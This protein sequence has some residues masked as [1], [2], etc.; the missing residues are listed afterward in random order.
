MT[1]RQMTCCVVVA[2]FC[3][4]CASPRGVAPPEPGAPEPAA[5]PA[6]VAKAERLGGSLIGAGFEHVVQAGDTLT[7]VS[8]RY[9]VDPR[10]LARENGLERSAGLRAGQRLRVTNLHI[11]PA[12][13]PAEGILINV[14]QRMLFLFRA[15][16]LAGA[17][18]VGLGRPDWQTPI[19]SYRIASRERDKA[20]IV[21]R[22]IQEEMRQRGRP[23][24]TRVEPGPDNPLGGY[25]L[26]LDREECGIHGTLAPASVYAFQSHG[27]VR[28]HRD[29]IDELFG[30]VEIGE[31]VRIIYRP[32]MVAHG[33]GSDVLLEVHPDVYD[34]GGMPMSELEALARDYGLAID[35][36][37]VRRVIAE[38]EGIP[39]SVGTTGSA[40]ESER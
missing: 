8:A 11:V 15:G 33:A 9:G 14:P 38:R 24:L 21:P 19:G 5:E 34:R 22:S 37:R 18:P 29:D 13:R 4:D 36:A 7:L 10:V 32:V 12:V 35:W 23:V 16:A 40:A 6:P 27:C 2:A 25:W 26:G 39:R 30:S 28:M 1:I 20:W 3:L 17:Y 31:E